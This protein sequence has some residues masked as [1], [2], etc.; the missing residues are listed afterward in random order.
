MR[1][2]LTILTA[3]FILFILS[4]T[5]SS[6]KDCGKKETKPDRNGKTIDTG[7]DAKTANGMPD[8]QPPQGP[9][10]PGSTTDAA[11]GV[12]TKPNGGGPALT[13][14][15]NTP[16]P[17]I[18]GSTPKPA[19][20]LQRIQA[21]AQTATDHAFKTCDAIWSRYD[22]SLC[23][24]DRLIKY[25]GITVDDVKQ[26]I[27][28]AATAKNKLKKLA[29]SQEVKDAEASADKEISN[30]A[31][32]IGL[33]LLKTERDEAHMIWYWARWVVEDE[34]GLVVRVR[35]S[36]EKIDTASKVKI[37]AASEKEKKATKEWNAKRMEAAKA[38]I[39]ANANESTVY[40][41]LEDM[42]WKIGGNPIATDF[43]N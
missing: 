23:N 17:N 36:D 15:S 21:L 40:G 10:V 22:H 3:S 18:P 42:W 20:T 35:T 34:N 32:V 4:F 33:L 14:S 12:T 19:P 37:D 31:K 6:C 24:L 1:S 11:I 39:K 8:G 13:L 5:L 30:T 26:V 7:S 41:I 28:K 16:N 9:V 43:L 29:D 38:D 25:K 27:H 2:V